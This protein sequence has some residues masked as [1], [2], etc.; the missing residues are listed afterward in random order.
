MVLALSKY[1]FDGPEVEIRLEK[2][3]KSNTLYTQSIYSSIYSRFVNILALC[4]QNLVIYIDFFQRGTTPA[5]SL[6]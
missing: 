6:A 4:V 5:A 3:K 1:R 2:R